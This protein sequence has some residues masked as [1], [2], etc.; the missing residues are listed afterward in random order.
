MIPQNDKFV[1]SVGIKPSKVRLM[2]EAST[3]AAGGH[4]FA[5][6]TLELALESCQIDDPTHINTEVIS[7]LLGRDQSSTCVAGD[8]PFDGLT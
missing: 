6:G 3:R 5:D 8:R 1:R 4:K 2:E 7:Q